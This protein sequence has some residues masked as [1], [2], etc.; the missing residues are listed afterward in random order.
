MGE[1]PD[2]AKIRAHYAHV[3]GREWVA[4]VAEHLALCDSLD[5][6]RA[7][8]LDAHETIQRVADYAGKLI[9]GHMQ[10]SLY[11]AL[12]RPAEPPEKDIC[13]Y[14]GCRDQ[15]MAGHMVTDSFFDIDPDDDT[16]WPMLHG[17]ETTGKIHI[18]RVHWRRWTPTPAP[19]TSEF[20]SWTG[21]VPDD[22]NGPDTLA[23]RNGEK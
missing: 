2:T 1:Q 23:E 5:A 4:S 9:P 11:V 15:F 13:K 7:L 21:T 19:E 17:S 16:P 12:E 20:G 10:T 18:H 14:P 6:T 8:L 3:D 22:Y